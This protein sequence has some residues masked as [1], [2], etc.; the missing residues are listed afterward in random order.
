MIENGY[1]K[2]PFWGNKQMTVLLVNRFS[3]MNGACGVIPHN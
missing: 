3:V 2:Y 1:G